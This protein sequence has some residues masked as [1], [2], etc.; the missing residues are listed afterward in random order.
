MKFNDFWQSDEEIVNE[1]EFRT[2][3]TE[4]IYAYLSEEEVDQLI[5]AIRDQ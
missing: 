2:F 1:E 4:E 3:I 5:N